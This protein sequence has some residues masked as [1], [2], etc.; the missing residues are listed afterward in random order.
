[1]QIGPGELE[2][3]ARTTL[4]FIERYFLRKEVNLQVKPAG[5]SATVTKPSAVKR[6]KHL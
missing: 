2:I 3:G 6:A 1:M 4:E 5:Y